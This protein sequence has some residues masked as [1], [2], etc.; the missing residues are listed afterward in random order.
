MAPDD[1]SPFYGQFADA[2]PYL[3]WYPCGDRA[4][5]PHWTASGDLLHLEDE[6]TDDAFIEA[7]PLG[8]GRYVL[9][10]DLS[11]P[12]GPRLRLNWGDEFEADAAEENH[13][14]LRRVVMPQ[15]YQHLRCRSDADLVPGQTTAFAA[16]AITSAYFQ[17]SNDHPIAQ[18]VHELEGGWESVAGCLLT[19][20]LPQVNMPVFCREM[21]ARALKLELQIVDSTA[22]RLRRLRRSGPVSLGRAPGKGFTRPQ[23]PL[24]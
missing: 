2:Q 17:F 14:V 7:L 24:K 5:G 21:Q 3:L 4:G 13:L 16:P 9:A 18:L 6:T 23:Q 19:L 22:S 1:P 11:G 15:R 10:A 20:T 12:F 8:E